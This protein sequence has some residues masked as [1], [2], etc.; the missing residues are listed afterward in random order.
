MGSTLQPLT[1][2]P[3]DTTRHQGH[4][5][6]MTRLD[7]GAEPMLS[8]CEHP[9]LQKRS[10]VKTDTRSFCGRLLLISGRGMRTVMSVDLLKQQLTCN[11]HLF[12]LMDTKRRTHFLQNKAAGFTPSL[13][14]CVCVCLLPPRPIRGGAQLPAVRE[15][16]LLISRADDQQAS[17]TAG[18]CVHTTHTHLPAESLGGASCV[19]LCAF[20]GDQGVKR[21]AGQTAGRQ[22]KQGNLPLIRASGSARLNTFLLRTLSCLFVF[23]VFTR[24]KALT[25]ECVTALWTKPGLRW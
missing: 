8:L 25:S 1:A 10:Q 12:S 4:N 5:R 17:H 20:G 13:T 15:T 24:F 19:C 7:V 14:L 22:E 18:H 11:T 21:L 3:L 9:S 2:L 6:H 23:C 16:K